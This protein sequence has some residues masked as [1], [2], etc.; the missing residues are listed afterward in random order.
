M[1]RIIT[2]FLSFYIF[3]NKLFKSSKYPINM[4]SISVFFQAYND[5]GTIKDIV[6]TTDNILKTITDDYEILI[7]DDAS[8]DNSGKIAD[9]LAKKNKKIRVIHHK[10]NKGIGGALVSGYRNSKKEYVFY[11]D[12]DAQYDVNEIRKL[13]NLLPKSDIVIGY[14][15]KRSDPLIRKLTSRGYNFLVFLL[16]GLN[17]RD[18]DCSFK[19]IKKSLIDQINLKTSSGFVDD[20]LL[21]RLKKINKKIIQVPVTHYPRK[22]GETQFFKFKP[23]Y[24]MLLDMFKIRFNLK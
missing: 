10:E 24:D 20:E 8:P 17:V 2:L 4:K 7:I 5:E 23:I 1:R 18:V 12:G 14:R 19:L 9:E 22:S 16:F 11:T 6:L 21:W 15:K 13:I 3:H